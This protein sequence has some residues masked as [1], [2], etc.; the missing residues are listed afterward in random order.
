MITDIEEYFA[1]GC[2]R[3]ARF[4][5]PDCST[6]TWADG[7]AALRRLCLEAGLEERVKWGHPCYL[8]AGR[9]IVIIGA[10]RG[11]FRLSFF[12]AAL[13][14]DPDGVLERPGPNTQHADM[15][16]FMTN[17]AVDRLAPV[18]GAYLA[19]SKG[20]AEAGIKPPSATQ[21]LELPKELIA[22]LDT[23]PV[24]AEAFH[25]LTPGRRKS[26]VLNL[27]GAKKPETRIARIEKFRDRILA[28][29]GA[30]ER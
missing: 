21:E 18:I 2:G 15:I 10:F 4:G 14:R 5:T 24:L 23:D 8:Y 3:C 11:D 25:A 1:R 9:N 16:R 13:M 22:A 20:Y 27:A 28:G 7:L 12:N 26:Y 30:T 17:G 6:R 29:K 19:E